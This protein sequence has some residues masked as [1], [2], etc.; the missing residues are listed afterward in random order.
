MGKA[1]V[2]GACVRRWLSAVLVVPVLA[3]CGDVV[4]PV[5]GPSRDVSDDETARPVETV[6]ALEV[7]L[8]GMSA[9]DGR[10]EEHATR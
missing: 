4:T 7:D 8:G 9:D 10:A 5:A 1:P 6:T 2:S 3:A